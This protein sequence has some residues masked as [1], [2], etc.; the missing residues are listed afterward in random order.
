MPVLTLTAKGIEGLWAGEARV[1]Y[2]DT[3]VKGLHVRV[4]PNG[5]RVFAVWYRV[6]QQL[7]A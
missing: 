1:D 3:E 2:W 6:H 5:E 4:S 7:T